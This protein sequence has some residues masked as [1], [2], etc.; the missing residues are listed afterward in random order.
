MATRKAFVA[1]HAMK[2]QTNLIQAYSEALQ[3]QGQC[4]S[5]ITAHG[6][7]VGTGHSLDD[8][9]SCDLLDIATDTMGDEPQLDTKRPAQALAAASAAL[10]EAMR[11]AKRPRHEPLTL[12][13]QVA[14]AQTGKGEAEQPATGFDCSDSY[15]DASF[16]LCMQWGLTS[17]AVLEIT[18][19]ALMLV[20]GT[21][22]KIVVGNLRLSQFETLLGL[23]SKQIGRT[24][25]NTH[26]STQIVKMGSSMTAAYDTT[27]FAL[28][29]SPRHVT[30]LVSGRD[31]SRIVWSILDNTALYQDIQAK[32]AKQA[33]FLLDLTRSCQ[34][35]FHTG[36][37]TFA[38]QQ[39]LLQ[40]LVEPMQQQAQRQASTLKAQQSTQQQPLKQPPKQ[41]E[42]SDLP[43]TSL[44]GGITFD[45][46]LSYPHVSV[47]PMACLPSAL[48]QST[49]FSLAKVEHGAL[50]S[51]VQLCQE[52]SS[53]DTLSVTQTESEHDRD[54]AGCGG[55]HGGSSSDSKG[56]V[57]T[58]TTM[59]PATQSTEPAGPLMGRVKPRR[60]YRFCSRCWIQK[61]EWVLRAITLPEGQSYSLNGHT[62]DTCPVWPKGNTPTAEQNRAYAAAFKFAQRRSFLHQIAM[63]AFQ[64]IMPEMSQDQLLS[65]LLT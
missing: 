20:D 17:P 33:Q 31:R 59:V 13:A 29:G 2:M 21:T 34:E 9:V 3:N 47:P 63:K 5:S 26:V 64:E 49:M 51:D 8:L 16:Q 65:Y 52:S 30:C 22:G 48:S 35:A 15:V 1:T 39:A 56:G 10:P 60:P 12:A 25:L 50:D 37:C 7:G 14:K 28:D 42:T 18:H 11:D 23:G 44:G 38:D 55:S 40:C 57:A 58:V 19:D 43:P 53:P 27:I 45:A 46:P 36:S 4:I 61:S 41:E 32:Q 24:I 6:L 54:S 62:N